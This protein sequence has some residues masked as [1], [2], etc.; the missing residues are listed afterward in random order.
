MNSCGCCQ[1]VSRGINNQ[2]DICLPRFP[3]IATFWAP[4]AISFE[5]ESL[6]VCDALSTPCTERFSSTLWC[7]PTSSVWQFSNCFVLQPGFSVDAIPVKVRMNRMGLRSSVM[8]IRR[9]QRER[10]NLL[11]GGGFQSQVETSR[12]RLYESTLSRQKETSL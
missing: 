11:C 8:T 10:L 7:R 3:F 12:S 1:E 5:Q 2:Q 4:Q 9:W 6:A